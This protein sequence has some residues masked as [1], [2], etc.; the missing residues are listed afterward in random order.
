MLTKCETTI[1]AFGAWAL[2]ALAVLMV[3]DSLE[4]EYYMMLCITGFFAIA[5][6]MGPYVVR[7]KWQSRLNRVMFAGLAVFLLLV[8]RKVMLLYGIK[9]F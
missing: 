1:A 8:A 4:I 9:P 5:G 6:V 3:M 7:P 2:F